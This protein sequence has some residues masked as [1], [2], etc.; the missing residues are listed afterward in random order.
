MNQS[1]LAALA[2]QESSAAALAPGHRG[3]SQVK[4]LPGAAT[5]GTA[6]EN[7]TVSLPTVKIF[8]FCSLMTK[9]VSSIVVTYLHQ[10]DGGQLGRPLRGPTPMAKGM[11]QMLL[12]LPL[13]IIRIIIPL[14][15]T[16]SKLLHT[17]KIL[18][19]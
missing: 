8:T 18:T 16:Y 1:G 19:C 7:F 3:L 17:V 13:S 10:I 6:N 15:I 5:F 11:E 2:L 9:S 4:K 14:R 12:C